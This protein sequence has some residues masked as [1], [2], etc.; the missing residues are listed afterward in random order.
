MRNI[1]IVI[2]RRVG[3]CHGFIGGRARAPMASRCEAR[4]AGAA[5]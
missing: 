2:A 5:P 1:A 4:T 3:A